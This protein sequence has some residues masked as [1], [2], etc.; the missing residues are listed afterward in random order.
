MTLVLDLNTT[1]GI[2]SLIALIAVFGLAFLQVLQQEEMNKLEGELDL[3]LGNTPT[4]EDA[5]LTFSQMMP[6]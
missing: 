2:L 4:P 3:A 1:N 5:P 6:K